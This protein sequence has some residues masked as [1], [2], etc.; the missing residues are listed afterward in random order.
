M[1]VSLGI[2][3]VVVVVVFWRAFA[4]GESTSAAPDLM[5]GAEREAPSR[6]A[7]DVKR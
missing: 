6:E 5:F 2:F 1:L 4:T 3:G 7:R